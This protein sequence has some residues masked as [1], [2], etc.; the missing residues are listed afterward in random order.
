MNGIAERI[1]AFR[2][3]E[4]NEHDL[5]QDSILAR[6]LKAHEAAKLSDVKH[7]ILRAHIRHELLT[8]EAV[9]Q[10]VAA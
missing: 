5:V 9:R 3:V 2:G 6:L 4:D 1:E 10:A 8:N 7:H